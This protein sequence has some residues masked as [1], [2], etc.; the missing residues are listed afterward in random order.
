MLICNK[1]Q[2][3]CAL[4]IFQEPDHENSDTE[5]EDFDKIRT[6]PQDMAPLR[7]TH[8][9]KHFKSNYSKLMENSDSDV[10]SIESL[11]DYDMEDLEDCYSTV[12]KMQSVEVQPAANLECQYTKK[13]ISAD[14]HNKELA[15]Q[16]TDCQSKQPNALDNKMISFGN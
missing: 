2:A 14:D 9:F 16:S 8:F 5:E 13:L 11:S 10:A 12:S 4:K 7:H 15:D 3:S 6:A 1:A